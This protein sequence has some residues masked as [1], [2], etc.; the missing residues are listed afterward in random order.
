MAGQEK[1]KG[2]EFKGDLPRGGG[3]LIAVRP[4]A[5]ETKGSRGEGGPTSCEKTRNLHR[6]GTRT[7]EVV[8]AEVWNT[9]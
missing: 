1:C 2:P 7:G 3:L 8:F 4:S 5:G 6:Y 9:W